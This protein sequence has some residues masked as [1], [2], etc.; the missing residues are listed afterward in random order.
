MLVTASA[1]TGKT[2]VLSG[3]CVD[4]VTDKSVCPD[5]LGILVLTFTDLAAEEMRSRIAEQLRTAFTTKKDSHLKRQLMLLAGADI[6]TIHSFCKKII[7]EFFYKLGIDPEFRVTDADE[8]KLLKDEILDK[9]ISWAWQQEN[10]TAGLEQLFGKRDLRISEG[11]ASKIIQISDFL[12][13]VTSRDKW[14]QRSLILAESANSQ[15]CELADKQKQLLLEKLTEIQSRIR[16]AQRLYT[17]Q[18]PDA[19]LPPKTFDSGFIETL[20]AAI[21]HC[22][23]DRWNDCFELIRNFKKPRVSTPKDFPKTL[24]EV[25]KDTLAA[26]IRDTVKEAVDLF[27]GL[28]SLAVV[29]PD[30]IS[31]VGDATSL[32]TKMLIELVRKFD[33]FYLRAKQEI[34]SMDFAD[35]E[36]YA[37]KLLTKDDGGN[38]IPTRSDT[39]K[40]LRSRYKYIFVDEYQDINPVQ[41]QIL[42]LL[43]EKGKL[44]VVGDV[45]QSI[46]AFRGAEPAIFLEQLRQASADP[47]KNAGSMRIDLNTN[48]RSDQRILDFINR[49]FSRIMASTVAGIDYDNAAM[50]KPCPENKTPETEDAKVVELH[51]LDKPV[52]SKAQNN[53]E[54][55]RNNQADP[56]ESI[57]ARRRQA[58]LI[59]RRIKEMVGAGDGKPQ[60]QIFDKQLGTTRNVEYRDIVILMRSPSVKVNEYVEILRLAA[61]P[62]SCP[63]ASGYFEKTEIS[64]CLC[65]LKILDNP[66]R[67]IELTAVLR[68][69]LFKITDSELAKIKIEFKKNDTEGNFYEAVINYAQNDTD[70]QLAEKI[71]HFLDTTEKWK[72]HARRGS[73]ADLLWLILRETGYLSFVSALPGGPQR[74]A[75]LLKLH[76]RA[77]QFEGFAGSAGSALLTRFIEFIQKLESKGRDWSNAEPEAEIENAVRIMSVHKSKG[78]EFPVVI[79]AELESSFNSADSAGDCLFR[80]DDTL[81][82][83]IIDRSSNSKISSLA[84]QVIAEQAKSTALAEEM[85]ILY[86]AMTRA[87]QRLILTGTAKTNKC[88]DIITQG[89]LFEQ[90]PLPSWQLSKCKSHLEWLLYAVCDQAPLH[91][92]FQTNLSTGIKN[93]DLFEFNLYTTG[94]IEKLSQYVTDLKQAGSSRGQS[95]MKKS[96]GKESILFAKVKQSLAWQYQFTD[97]PLLP[98]KQSVTQLTHQYDEYAVI[99]YS[100]VTEKTPQA[101]TPD[102]S[103]DHIDSRLIGTATHLLISRL[104]L[105]KPVTEEIIRRTLEILVSEAAISKQLAEKIRIESVQ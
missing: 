7:T 5:V 11:F 97:L 45:K 48:F 52:S 49:I 40:A 39:A 56:P 70:S 66:Q 61:V 53:D 54:E 3:R 29:D 33:E 92:V 31:R 75:N 34:N 16:H 2:A 90:A 13:T 50:L 20:T 55:N 62:V 64:D 23:S 15:T 63:G 44:F 79:L 99:D 17:S 103:A 9:T 6:S 35:L 88:R 43:S 46:Y 94:D 82:L 86:V 83:K 51:I 14:Y 58:A 10:L 22:R 96:K 69:P 57:D 78:L 89:L 28:T 85:R 38:D 36:H 25:V 72:T 95:A 47:K 105:K 37:L 19:P 21:E 73:L 76:D 1:G 59:A 100:R 27:A 93:D 84:Y 87:K 30:Y 91:K 12:D 65:L 60:F 74:R 81:G 80:D 77:I 41:Q 101:L 102:D 98:A 26:V 8:Q 32:Q 42:D 68:S 71:K 104:D 18:A 67:D 24:T 4:I